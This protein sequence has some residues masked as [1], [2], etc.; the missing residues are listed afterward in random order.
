MKNRSKIL[1]LTIL[2]LLLVVS[3]TACIRRN[4]DNPV[5]S[6]SMPTQAEKTQSSATMTQSTQVVAPTEAPN[7]SIVPTLTTAPAT[8][9]PEISNNLA[10]VD[11]LLKELDQILGNTDTNVVIP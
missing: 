1:S 10:E 9:P 4:F 2:M 3:L 5:N 6:T 7:T 11:D 8:V